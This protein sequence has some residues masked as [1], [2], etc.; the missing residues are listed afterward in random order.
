[1]NTLY[2]LIPD[3]LKYK[4][5]KWYRLKTIDEYDRNLLD[6]F[7]FIF[8]KK[9]ETTIDD[10]KLIDIDEYTNHLFTLPCPKTSIYWGENPHLS[11]STI[12]GKINSLRQFFQYY[13]IYHNMGL[14]YEQIEVPRYKKPEMTFINEKEFENLFNIIEKVEL[15]E[16][17][18][19]R[20]RVL[21]YM[22]YTTWMRV[23]ELLNIRINQ[24][25]ENWGEI[26]IKG[27]WDVI[28]TIY[29]NS[30]CK[31]YIDEYLEFRYGW[32]LIEWSN[33]AYKLNYN[34][35]YL[36]VSMGD[37]AFG[38]KMTK[39]MVC[40]IFQKYRKALKTNKRITCHTLRHSF[41]TL[42]LNNNVP[43]RTIQKML[44]HQ[45]ITTTQTY[46][47]VVNKQLETVHQ[48]IFGE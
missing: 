7:K 5:N 12:A 16:D 35:D 37:W 6:F 18:E 40:L 36:L 39:Q 28:R 19:A 34:T 26:T 25:P 13:N 30:Q 32:R 1:M 17:V 22:A 15:R 45:Y 44:G 48:Q 11:R 23:S 4:Q 21:L 27:K 2:G 46:T 14:K 3:F 33:R 47:H 31:K 8:I 24:I 9:W 10:I 20:N 42:L 41:A 38:K 29:I 43:M